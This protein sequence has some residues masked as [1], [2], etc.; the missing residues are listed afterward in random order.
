[1][2]LQN[3]KLLVPRCR[4]GAMH[5]RRAVTAEKNVLSHWSDP[6]AVPWE[7]AYCRFIDGGAETQTLDPGLLG[8]NTEDWRGLQGLPLSGPLDT[9]AR[10]YTGPGHP[11][12]DRIAREAT[13]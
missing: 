2:L 8:Q 12:L 9:M 11:G 13:T 5:Q 4:W 6:G 7:G 3:R 10:L 1:M